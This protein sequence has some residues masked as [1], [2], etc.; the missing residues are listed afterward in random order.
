MRVLTFDGLMVFFRKLRPHDAVGRIHC[1]NAI[2][3]SFEPLQ[4][5]GLVWC[6]IGSALDFVTD[7]VRDQD[8]ALEPIYKIKPVDRTQ[9][10]QRS[11]VWND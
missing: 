6:N 10:D 8:P 7:H 2:A 5:G 1:L 4:E 3:A 11:R 9:G